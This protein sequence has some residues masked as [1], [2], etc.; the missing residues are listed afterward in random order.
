MIH[1]TVIIHQLVLAFQ[2]T[3]FQMRVKLLA[4][5]SKNHVAG[6]AER[7]TFLIA[8]LAHQGI[9]HIRKGH[10]GL[11]EGQAL[12]EL[13]GRVRRGRVDSPGR[14]KR[15]CR[16]GVKEGAGPEACGRPLF[17]IRKAALRPGRHN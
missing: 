17:R 11:R 13:E 3:I 14:H 6:F 15:A 5:R 10:E 16:S 9:I 7:H 1:R 8:S 2:E 4:H 12:R